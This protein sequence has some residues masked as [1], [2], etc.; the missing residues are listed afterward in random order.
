V[1][2]RASAG[3][4]VEEDF[5][6]VHPTT[7]HLKIA[8]NLSHNLKSSEH[9]INSPTKGWIEANIWLLPKL[10]QNLISLA[11]AK[12]LGLQIK[13]PDEEDEPFWIE[14]DS[15]EERRSPGSV[16]L[17]RREGNSSDDMAFRVHCLVYDH[18]HVR[19]IVFGA[20]FLKK[21]DYHLRRASTTGERGYG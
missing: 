10:S 1:I 8:S 21:R 7:Y 9:Y 16:V 18:D 19:R 12:K 5:F 14:V 15:G 13:P 2:K 6:L 20:P 4:T 3:P 17:E 11:Y